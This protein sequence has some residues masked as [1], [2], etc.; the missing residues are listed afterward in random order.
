M[1]KLFQ[2][3]YM[4]KTS[5]FRMFGKK[6]KTKGA[7]ILKTQ[8]KALFVEFIDLRINM[9]GNALFKDNSITSICLCLFIQKAFQLI[10]R[11]M[12]W[13]S[14]EMV[15]TYVLLQRRLRLRDWIFHYVT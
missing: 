12:S 9:T 4:Y 3:H 8:K 5:R 2:W 10:N 7:N 11:W 15:N 6:S 1:G 13:K 14:L